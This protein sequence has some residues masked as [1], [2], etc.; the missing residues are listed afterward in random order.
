MDLGTDQVPT[1]T[2]FAGNGIW[3]RLVRPNKRLG[4]LIFGAALILMTTAVVMGL[5]IWIL[6]E[7][8]Y[9]RER[10]RLIGLAQSQARAIEDLARTEKQT[11]EV[12]SSD[13]TLAQV[14]RLHEQYADLGGTGE[15]VLAKRQGDQI[16]FLMSHGRS[17]NAI[18]KP[19][20][21]QSVMAEP[22][23]RALTGL[24]GVV[25][26]LDYRAVTV[27]AAYKPIPSLNSGFVA[28]ID[29]AEF[30]GP[31]IKAGL[32]SALGASVIIVLGLMLFLW[33]SGTILERDVLAS[34]LR[35]NEQRFQD[36]AQSASDWHWELNPDL[37]YTFVSD[38]VTH[39]TNRQPDWFSNLTL[40][41]IIDRHFDRDEWQPFFDAFD[42]RCAFNNLVVRRVDVDGSEKW[43]SLNG[44][45][46]FDAEGNFE[47][48]RGTASDVS[49]IIKIQ[50]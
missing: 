20:A 40:N 18:P 50:E 25:V 21:W 11:D 31:Y 34:S 23:R 10:S 24:S 37:R 33:V 45:P 42:A 22:M 41:D 29:L 49:E 35:E 28:K 26:A 44:L 12:G 9:Q 46:V 32:V 43:I 38:T 39:I 4:V 5:S 15:F 17:E 13:R 7:S 27:M 14:E 2:S 6:Y 8:A 19:V 3:Q 30:R 36:F 47:C 1:N 16:V 48:F